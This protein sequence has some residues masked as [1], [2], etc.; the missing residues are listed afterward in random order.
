MLFWSGCVFTVVWVLFSVLLSWRDGTHL[1]RLFLKITPTH[2]R[3]HAS[4]SR[5][6]SPPGQLSCPL[7]SHFRCMFP[8]SLPPAL[9]AGS[10]GILC[11]SIIIPL[12][13]KGRSLSSYA[14]LKLGSWLRPTLSPAA[15]ARAPLWPFLARVPTPETSSQRWPKEVQWRSSVFVFTKT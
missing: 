8:R 13:L 4:Y 7:V 3:T 14:F 2:T 11:S 10:F 5:T 9:C 12:L 6:R 1:N 15:Y